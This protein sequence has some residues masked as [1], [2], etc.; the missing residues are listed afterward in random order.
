MPSEEFSLPEHLGHIVKF[1]TYG[2]PQGMP[3]L[4]FHGGPGSKSRPEHAERFD[5]TKYYVIL[6]DQRGCGKSLPLG[7]LDHN[8]TQNT[9][10][11]AERIRQHLCIEKWFVSG[12]S[13][14]STC[15]LLY[16]IEHP[17]KVQG[18]LISSIFLADE[19]SIAYATASS[20]GAARFVP[21]AWASRMNF[22]REF[23]IRLENQSED[24]S[25]VFENASLETEQKIAACILNWEGSLLS[26][27]MDISNIKPSAI[28]E[29]DIAFAK[30]SLHYAKHRYFISEGYILDNIRKIASI[31]AMIVHGRYDI[32]CPIEKAFLLKEHLLQA[33]LVVVNSSG[34]RFSSEGEMIRFLSYAKF[35][36][37]LSRQRT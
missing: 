26:P 27:S 14:G 25:K 22:F 6:F 28:K 21:D 10:Y 1:S 24:L 15:A 35:L 3:I 16:A 17:D 29:T 5:L 11:D 34:H 36:E 32:L 23:N 18:L 4:C 30:I 19:D 20:K 8:N 33:N 7:K 2:N 9:L 12:S 37:N 13:F 31:P